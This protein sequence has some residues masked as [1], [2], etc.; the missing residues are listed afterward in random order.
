MRFLKLQP[1]RSHSR[2]EIEKGKR[3]HDFS[4]CKRLQVVLPLACHLL[5][6]GCVTTSASKDGWIKEPFPGHACDERA[7]LIRAQ[8]PQKREMSIR[9]QLTVLSP[10]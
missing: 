9:R 6:L 10:L 8:S 1:S 2:W 3:K 5:E 7:S 4:L